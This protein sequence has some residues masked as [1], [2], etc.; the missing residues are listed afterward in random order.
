MNAEIFRYVLIGA[1]VLL[2]YYVL[3]GQS[4][5]PNDGSI[6]MYPDEVEMDED[7]ENHNMNSSN[8]EN[9]SP[10]GIQPGM[11]HD[12][13]AMQMTSGSPMANSGEGF[14]N[15]PQVDNELNVVANASAGNR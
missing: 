7:E 12:M 11:T 8:M 3:T 6:M 14:Q 1:L 15:V 4:P 13:Y 9:S 5:I 10:M 2:L